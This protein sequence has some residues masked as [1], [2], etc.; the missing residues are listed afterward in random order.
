M[1]AGYQLGYALTAQVHEPRPIT[2]NICFSI[3]PTGVLESYGPELISNKKAAHMITI[4][5]HI[6]AYGTG[7]VVVY[8]YLKFV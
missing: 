7:S 1:I 6:W 2:R 4:T 5:L 8:L 3:K